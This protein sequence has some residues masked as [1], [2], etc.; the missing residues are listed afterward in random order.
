MEIII[1]NSNNQSIQRNQIE[2]VEKEKMEYHLLGKFVRTPGLALFCFNTETLEL[3]EV[4]PIKNDTVAIN[5]F[6]GRHWEDIDQ[7][8]E[9]LTVD[10]RNIHFEALNLKNA[11]RK[12]FRYLKNPD[13][14]PL[15]NLKPYKE[16]TLIRLF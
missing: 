15:A 5:F 16:P 13:L 4:K 1:P 14:F 7:A 11:K 12:V 9:T 3:I 10:S 6:E 8:K 2:V